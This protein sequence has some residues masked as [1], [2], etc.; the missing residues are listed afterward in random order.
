MIRVLFVCMGNICRSPTAEGVFRQLLVNAGVD[1]IA[2][3]SAG[4]IGYHAGEPP[5]RRA[6]EA[7]ARRGV[8]LSNQRA[9]RVRTQ[10][11]NDFD[12]VLAMDQD[13][14]NDLAAQCP[15]DVQHKLHLFLEFAPGLGVKDV[16]DPYYGRDD[17]FEY[18]LDL[19][20]EAARALLDDIRARHV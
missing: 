11:F 6:I 14:Y 3:D 20:E 4:T 2:V 13:N 17:G 9:R 19:V 15:P 10:D 8:D 1:G 16:P 18:A 12:Y 7:A 5:D